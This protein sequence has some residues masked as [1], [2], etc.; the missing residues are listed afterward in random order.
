MV[1][2]ETLLM[3]HGKFPANES[4]LL[5]REASRLIVERDGALFRVLDL[6]WRHTAQP[7]RKKAVGHIFYGRWYSMTWGG[8]PTVP[9][10]L[11]DIFL[12]NTGVVRHITLKH[13]SPHKMYVHRNN[14]YP[15]LTPSQRFTPPLT[16][17]VPM[18]EK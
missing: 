17:H 16:H 11:K 10:E 5:L 2:Y 1:F 7:V 15:I 3:L 4:R 8:P 6:G 12:H 9:Q 14:F 18:S 13:S